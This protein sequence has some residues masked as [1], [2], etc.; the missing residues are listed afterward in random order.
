MS[1]KVRV[2]VLFG[3]KSG[4]HDVSL[5]SASSVLKAMDLQKYE[6]LPVAITKEGKWR[7]G[8]E[9]LSLLEGKLES[10]WI[11]RL[12]DE[13]PTI[14]SAVADSTLPSFSTEEIDVVFPVLHGTYGEDGT[15]QGLWEIA[16][17][18]YVGAGVLASSVG[19]DKV[20]SKKVFRDEGIPQG[21]FTYL[22][23][24]RWRKE[25]EKY[26][27]QIERDFE[28]PL[29]V[30]PANLGSSVGIS[31][32][33]NRDEL[34]QA[35]ELAAKYDRKIVVEEFIPAR[36]I[37]VAVL[38]NDDPKASMPGEIISSNEFYDYEAKYQ[39]G[40][41]IIDIPAKLPEEKIE[42]IRRLAIRAYQAIDCSGLARV[43]FFYR[44]DNGEI[45][46]NEINTMPGFTK[47]SMYPK[48]WEYA[49]IPYS[50]LIDRLIQLALD[51]YE[52]KQ[53]S[54]TTFEELE[55]KV[56]D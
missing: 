56:Q 51:R 7:L 5:H 45:L 6:V 34:I 47:Y 23:R 38:G 42:E 14:T 19:M 52:E 50:E 36:E 15:M 31:K 44:K 10:E 29:F 8:K 24:N 54:A 2:A 9:A 4:E 30:K 25:P 11:E 20:L 49:G 17:L 21:R 26:L 41:S 40:T 53:Q 27:E 39:S 3:G 16:N 13:V 1:K 33:S 22:L 12:S 35:I 28:Y 48:M 37:E 32:A 43:D 46:I 18:P 55:T